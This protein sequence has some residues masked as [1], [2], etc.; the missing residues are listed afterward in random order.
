M[1]A[2]S[3]V[4][5]ILLGGLAAAWQLQSRRMSAVVREE[6]IAAH[7][8]VFFRFLIWM[9]QIPNVNRRICPDFTWPTDGKNRSITRYCC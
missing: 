9:K 5:C 6:A 3:V 8:I 2:G 7:S 1:I 4:A